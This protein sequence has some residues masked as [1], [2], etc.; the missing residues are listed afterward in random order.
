VSRQEWRWLGIQL[1]LLLAFGAV[2]FGGLAGNLAGDSFAFLVIPLIV[3]V[4]LHFGSVGVALALPL[5]TLLAVWGYLSGR[6][7]GAVSPTWS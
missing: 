7:P 1:L 3:W 2:V 6:W 5:V 4:A